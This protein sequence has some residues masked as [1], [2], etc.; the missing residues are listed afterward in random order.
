MVLILMAAAIFSGVIGDLKDSITIFIILFVNAT[1]G[2][3]QEYRAAKAVASIRTLSKRGAQTRRDG[4][5]Q[6]I[7]AESRVPAP[8]GIKAIWI[9]HD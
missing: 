7:P 4:K 5:L 9:Y 1:L 8:L 3:I 6:T 2:F